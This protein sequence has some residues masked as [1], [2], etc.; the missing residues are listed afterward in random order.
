MI[1]EKITGAQAALLKLAANLTGAE[2]NVAEQVAQVLHHC[3]NTTR[4]LE[5][6]PLPIT[7][8]VEHQTIQ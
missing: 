5:A 3:A 4:A 7:E 2:R 6:I 1:T 8:P